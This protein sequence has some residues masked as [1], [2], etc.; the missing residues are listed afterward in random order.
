MSWK[1]LWEVVFDSRAQYWE[2]ANQT[3]VW[4]KN[5]W[6]RKTVSAKALGQ[7]KRSEPHGGRE[8]QWAGLGESRVE[9]QRQLTQGFVLTVG[10]SDLILYSRKQLWNFKQMSDAVWVMVVKDHIVINSHSVSGTVCPL[11]VLSFHLPHTQWKGTIIVAS[12]MSR[13]KLRGS[14]WLVHLFCCHWIHSRV[15]PEP[16][17]CLWLLALNTQ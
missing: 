9:Q 2:G 15:R 11:W 10:S 13:L 4:A 8:D 3:N 5:V 7:S 1:S 16:V 6:G 14:M 12:Q 17:N